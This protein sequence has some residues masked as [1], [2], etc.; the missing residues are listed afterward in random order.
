VGAGIKK[1]TYIEPYPKS[2]AYQLHSD[3]IIFPEDDPGPENIKTIFEPFVG[4]SPAMYWKLFSLQTAFGEKLKR[5]TKGGDVIEQSS[6]LR[7][8]TSPYS[9]TYR[10]AS[11]AVAI[12][13]KIK[14]LEEGT[15]GE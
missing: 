6:G 13:A 14:E 12:K 5:K 9:Y 2:L 11:A 15:D 8:F 1:A 10:E 7:L 4:V 3:S